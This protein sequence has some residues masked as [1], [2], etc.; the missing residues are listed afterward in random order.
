MVTAVVAETYSDVRSL[1]DDIVQAHHRKYGGNPDDLRA[2]ANSLFIEAYD[3]YDSNK[4]DFFSWTKYFVWMRLLYNRRLQLRE[5]KRYSDLNDDD[6]SLMRRDPSYFDLEEFISAI[7]PDAG[8]VVRLALQGESQQGGKSE[9]GEQGGRRVKAHKNK[10]GSRTKP[11][12]NKGVGRPETR[13]MQLKR[14]LKDLGWSLRRIAS[15]FTE[16]RE[17]L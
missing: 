9:Q 6:P 10:G 7:S 16:I 13:G 8:M 5:S 12:P 4:G 14:Y 17:A 2:D 1:L 3:K 11:L 15:T